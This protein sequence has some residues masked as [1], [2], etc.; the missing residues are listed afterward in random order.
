[1]SV[2]AEEEGRPVDGLGGGLRLVG[3]G[4]GVGVGVVRLVGGVWVW[5]GLVVCLVWV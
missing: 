1:V 3:V 5:L 2:A 4:V